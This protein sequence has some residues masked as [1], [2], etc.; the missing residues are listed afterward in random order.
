MSA[1]VTVVIFVFLAAG[2]LL[3]GFSSLLK[4]PVGA[5]CADSAPLL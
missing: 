1:R 3:D 5:A 4:R 2:F